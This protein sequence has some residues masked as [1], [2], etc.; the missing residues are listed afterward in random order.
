MHSDI[1]GQTF[2]SSDENHE[3]N[4]CTMKIKYVSLV[5]GIIKQK[6]FFLR[7]D[8]GSSFNKESILAMLIFKK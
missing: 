7:N 5:Y 1:G 3:S 4:A 6:V 2:I 8:F